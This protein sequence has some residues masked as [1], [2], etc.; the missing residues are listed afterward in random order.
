MVQNVNRK[1][2]EE[3]RDKDIT[4][5]KYLALIKGHHRMKNNMQKMQQKIIYKAKRTKR[6]TWNFKM[7]KKRTT[8]LY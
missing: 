7:N 2:R 1:F 3:S 8:R 6:N 4:L 5:G